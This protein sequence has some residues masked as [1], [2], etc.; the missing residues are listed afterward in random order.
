MNC[1][2]SAT[3]VT[4]A[5]ALRPVRATEEKAIPHSVHAVIPS[6]ETQAKVSQWSAGGTGRS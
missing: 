3:G 5:G 4:T 6:T 2:I 1:R